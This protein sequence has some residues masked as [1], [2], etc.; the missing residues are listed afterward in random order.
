MAGRSRAKSVA[1]Q[2]L[3][4]KELK[5]EECKRTAIKQFHVRRATDTTHS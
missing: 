4:T 1:I 5:P 3:Q 2:I